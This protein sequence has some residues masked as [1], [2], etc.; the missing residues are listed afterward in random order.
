[1][2]TLASVTPAVP[3]RMIMSA[4]MFMNEAG[5]VP[6]IIELMIREP[7][8]SPIPMAVA[9]FIAPFHRLVHAILQSCTAEL[10]KLTNA[11][12][13][14]AQLSARRV[15]DRGEPRRLA[16]KS[17]R[18]GRRLA[19]GATTA[20]SVAEDRDRKRTR[21]NSS[22]LGISYAVFCLKKKT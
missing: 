14:G 3:P 13:R 15:L 11:P 22:H 12:Q 10:H 2:P 6:S 7:K 16:A 1:M 4:G 18:P 8:A 9:A 5:L 19:R 17:R 20:Q 21:L